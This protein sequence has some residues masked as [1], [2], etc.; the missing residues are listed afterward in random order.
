M[1]NVCKYIARVKGDRKACYA[2][3]SGF[4]AFDEKEIVNT[5]ESESGYLIEF[6]GDCK[7][8]LDAYC[9]KVW[10]GSFPADLSGY[11][12]DDL[13]GGY[14]TDFWYYGTQ[15]LSKITDTEIEAISW[16]EESGFQEYVRYKNGKLV[17]RSKFGVSRKSRL[18]EELAWSLKL[19]LDD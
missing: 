11:S 9:N 7:W 8:E 10:D 18:P 6:K 13:A 5:S 16:S 2:V 4:S 17:T 3:Y 19:S 1:A 15:Q 14:C 12:E